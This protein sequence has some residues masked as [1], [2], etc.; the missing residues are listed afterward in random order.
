MSRRLLATLL[1][2]AAT[3]V[4]C[5]A[6]DDAADPSSATTS[7]A[8]TTPV[9]AESAATAPQRIVSLSPSLTEM[10][11][12][13]GAGEQVVAVDKYSDFPAG[14]PMTELSGF[15][16]NVEALAELAPDL[17][18]LASDRDGIVD[19]LET[20]GIPSL[21]L[22]TA[23]TLEDTYEQ[24]SEVGAVTGHPDEA[25]AVV[26]TMRDRI[27]ALVAEVPERE[28]PLT[29]YY[30]LADDGHSVTSATFI[31]NVLSL[32]GLV[33]IADDAPEAAGGYPQ[34]SAEAVLA[35]DPA[36]VFLAH[37]DG[38]TP[39]PA[40]LAARPGWGELRAIRDGHVVVLD[41][42]VASRW[43]P[44]VVDLLA[45]VVAATSTAT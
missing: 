35:A 40:E 4:A 41:T 43:G 29:Y 7:P 44:R 24:L 37:N 32:A 1:V 11:Y 12:A 31:G 38:T 5:G 25:A 26:A 9:S 16:P 33:S 17:V 13:V 14:T 18:V 15:K 3:A 2:V 23:P 21:L 34:L 28:A 30:E 10:L 45:A 6:E 20:V 22:P 42:D 27:D 36:F 39:T 19:A 8:T